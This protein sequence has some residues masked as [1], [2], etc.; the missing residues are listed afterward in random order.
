MANLLAVADVVPAAGGRLGHLDLGDGPL[1]RGAAPDRDGK[2]WG[3]Y[4]LVPWSNRIPGGH[5]RHGAIDA[6]LPPDHDD[7]S[8]I[9]GLAW[10]RPWRVDEVSERAVAL[11]IDLRGGPYEVGAR[12]AYD[13]DPD[14]I[15]IALDAT[16]HGP[17][18]VPVGLGIHPWFRAGAVRVPA[19]ARWPG[20]PLP[21]GPP[22]PAVGPY[23]LRRATVPIPMDVCFTGLTEPWADVPGARVRWEVPSPRSSSTAASPGGSASSR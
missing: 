16:N 5:L 10:D 20:E 8:A 18:A 3:C 23:D 21:T 6:H 11:S 2:A 14:G 22:V 19:A 12:L 1:L 7:G 15:T 9:H 17:I 13:L 4:P